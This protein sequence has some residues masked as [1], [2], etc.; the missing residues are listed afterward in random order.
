MYTYGIA[1]IDRQTDRHKFCPRIRNS[2]SEC[3]IDAA[4]D[5]TYISCQHPCVCHPGEKKA[6]K[7]NVTKTLLAHSLMR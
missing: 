4:A 5:V 2:I 7:E 3:H 6:M 1:H